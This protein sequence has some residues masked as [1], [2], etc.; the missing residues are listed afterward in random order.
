MKRTIWIL[1]GA[2]CLTLAAGGVLGRLAA[3]ARN[4]ISA[5]AGWLAQQ[6]QLT[7]EQRTQ[8]Q[9]IWDETHAR[10][11]AHVAEQ[12]EIENQFRQSVGLI[13]TDDQKARY[14]MLEDQFDQQSK[15]SDAALDA[16]I[17][18]SVEKTKLIL[19]PEQ[20][21]KYEQLLARFPSRPEPGSAT[22]HP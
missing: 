8:V 16:Q 15:L 1:L 4:S 12:R 19:T 10:M 21:E 18:A 20:R 22:S 6:L 2:F 17:D 9:A 11:D 5:D 13:L 14:K 7:P 3:P